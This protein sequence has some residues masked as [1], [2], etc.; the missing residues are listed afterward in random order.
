MKHNE[1]R[2]HAW[3]EKEHYSSREALNLKGHNAM[4]KDTCLK[5]NPAKTKQ[6]ISFIFV[7]PLFVEFLI[8]LSCVT[9][10]SVFPYYRFYRAVTQTSKN[11]LFLQNISG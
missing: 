2:H 4:L 10:V 3:K 9:V 7:F 1:G 5:Q 6:K 11:A 8:F